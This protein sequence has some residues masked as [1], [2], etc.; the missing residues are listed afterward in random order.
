MREV[1]TKLWPIWNKIFLLAKSSINS[2]KLSRLKLKLIKRLL[3]KQKMKISWH[4][5]FKMYIKLNL[6]CEGP[7]IVFFIL[8]MRIT[9]Q[10]WINL[11]KNSTTLYRKKDTSAFWD[12]HMDW[13]KYAAVSWIRSSWKILGLSK[14]PIHFTCPSSRPLL[15]MIRL[16][17]IPSL[18]NSC[19]IC[20]YMA[21]LRSIKNC[22]SI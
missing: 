17:I 19:K 12:T 1:W 18:T 8:K 21:F 15:S 3:K 7:E 9:L 14:I 5:Y 6:I 4:S 22:N 10:L 11:I 2:N 16:K 20:T 13:L